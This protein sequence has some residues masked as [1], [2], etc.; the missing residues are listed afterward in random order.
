MIEDMVR[1]KN[2]F[3][4]LNFITTTSQ[5]EIYLSLGNP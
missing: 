1:I 2:M 5:Q 3:L 4:L